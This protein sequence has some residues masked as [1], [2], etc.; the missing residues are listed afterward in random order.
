MDFDIRRRGAR[1]TTLSASASGLVVGDN[2]PELG[3]DLVTAL[4]TLDRD[5]LAHA[6]YEAGYKKGRSNEREGGDFG[7]A[8]GRERE[9]GGEASGRRYG[10]CCFLER[11]GAR[12]IIASA[13]PTVRD[14]RQR[15]G[16]WTARGALM[17]AARGV[18]TI[19]DLGFLARSRAASRCRRAAGRTWYTR[20]RV[21]GASRRELHFLFWF[22]RLAVAVSGGR[23][24]TRTVLSRQT[25]RL[26]PRASYAPA[27]ISPG[28]TEL[29]AVCRWRR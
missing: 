9:R 28:S 19:W 7:R 25:A 16:T 26:A 10:F 3:T 11:G 14:D 6:V 2:L 13:A 20:L 21:G 4:A 8:S 18:G 29:I 22:C 17:R 24:R 23:A 12:D 5:D 15:A 27:Q 1:W